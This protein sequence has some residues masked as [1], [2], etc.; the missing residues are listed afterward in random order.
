M[1]T[2]ITEIPIGNFQDYNRFIAIEAGIGS[3][4]EDVDNHL[5][6][7]YQYVKKNDRKNLLVELQNYR[8][9][10]AFV[11]SK[12]SPG[13]LAFGPLVAKVNGKEWEDRSEEGYNR[14]LSLLASK[15]FPY[16]LISKAVAVVKKNLS[17]KRIT[18]FRKKQPTAGN[19][20]CWLDL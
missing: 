18:I 5:G 15:G 1:Y 7:I 11:V 12:T 16:G 20:N 4:M 19:V 13:M 8:Q 17:L 2:S 3:T 6:R 14:L 9:N 10:L